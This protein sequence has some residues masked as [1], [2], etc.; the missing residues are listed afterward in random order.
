[1]EQ[2]YCLEICTDSV[3]SCQ[4]AEK[5]G[6]A[7]IELCANLFE[8]GTTPSAGTIQ[9][10]RQVTNIPLHIL[11]RPRGGDFYYSAEEFAVI[12]QDIQ[13]AKDLG[14]NGVV[15]G[16]LTPD[17]EI[18]MA[19]TATLIEIA[20]PLSITFHRAFDMARDP[21][22]SLEQLITLGVNRLLTSGQERSALEGS[23]LIS[24]LVAKAAGKIIIMPGGGI[25]LRNIQ[26][27]K[28]ETG[29]DEFHLTA[30]KKIT[31]AMQ[32]RQ[33]NVFMGGELR[34][35]EHEH[36]IADAEL[37]TQVQSLLNQ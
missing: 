37:I 22:R 10:A 32:Y 24:R 1:M 5:G 7:R 9:V 17:G 35:P 19:R 29:A 2:K 13:V 3:V 25:T 27:L 21:V 11:I 20:R 14:A 23:E 36:S 18:D 16:I 30:R 6:A 12:K 8:G 15:I 4:E 26:R 31:S 33:N 28:K 34:L